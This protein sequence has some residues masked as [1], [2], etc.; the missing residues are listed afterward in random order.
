[1]GDDLAIPGPIH[2]QPTKPKVAPLKDAT[3]YD[4]H[5]DVAS[6]DI[7]HA[8]ID[9]SSNVVHISLF[10]ADCIYTSVL[11]F[12]LYVQGLECVEMSRGTCWSF[13]AIISNGY[14]LKHAQLRVGQ[15]CIFFS[16][17]AMLQLR[18]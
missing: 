15:L 11:F 13:S 17:R 6:C 12:N 2:A 16:E 8:Q 1:M 14:A 4:F 7:T 10:D 5:E 18:K 3:T 9:R